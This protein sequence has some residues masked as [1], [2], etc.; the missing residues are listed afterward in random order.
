M[1][2]A[3]MLAACA[4]AREKHG[5][6]L[7]HFVRN[8][9]KGSDAAQQAA[10]LPVDTQKLIKE[11]E[12]HRQRI[13]AHYG[14]VAANDLDGT[15]FATT[16][17]AREALERALLR[18]LARREVRIAQLGISTT[19]GHDI[20]HSESFP[21]VFARHFGA[22]LRTA[23][24]ELRMRNHAVGGFGTMPSHA[25]AV[26]MAGHDNDVVAWDYM[27][28]AD[29]GSCAVE[30]LSRSLALAAPSVGEA[31]AVLWWQGG[32]WL[33]KEAPRYSE[34]RPPTGNAKQSCRNKWIVN[35]YASVGAHGGDFG[36]T[37]QRLRHGGL[38]LLRNGTDPLFMDPDKGQPPA[39]DFSEPELPRRRLARHHAAAPLNRLWG[40]AWCHAYLGILIEALEADA[41][42]DGPPGHAVSEL[43]PRAGC[44]ALLCESRYPTCLTSMTPRVGHALEAAASGSRTWQLRRDNKFARAIATFGYLDEKILLA[45]TKADGEVHVAIKATHDGLPLVACEAPC[46][47]GRCPAGRA[48]LRPNSRWTLDG[49]ALRVP[50][51]APA[52]LRL[53]DVKDTCFVV[54]EAI[55]AGDH[56]LGLSATVESGYV[57]L[58]HV[59]FY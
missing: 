23:G 28:M 5:D 40:L 16:P 57:G 39:P 18:G 15:I 43:P 47:W 31:P 14:G 56:V 38:A 9:A 42:L 46:P 34:P 51:E 45:G 58:S 4:C 2:R 12:R 44:E 52:R 17:R 6:D 22:V 10:R 55:S 11:A 25:C 59:I 53:F 21:R 13:R 35:S 30:L 8:Y 33:P 3:V 7:A 37:L 19:A 49:A 54:A 32:V 1:W 50:A 41:R 26:T 27:M 20:Y 36:A 29:R 24:V 48:P